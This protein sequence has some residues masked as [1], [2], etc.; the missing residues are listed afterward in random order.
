MYDLMRKRIHITALHLAALAFMNALSFAAIAQ[1]VTFTVNRTTDTTGSCTA[2]SCNLR[3]A[4]AAANATTTKDTIVFN[5][6]TCGTNV[7]NITGGTLHITRPVIIDGTT[8]PRCSTT[9]TGNSLI[10]LRGQGV[11]FAPVALISGLILDSTS[12]GSTIRG[13]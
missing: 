12:G 2:S 3:Q 10:E 5:L 9:P 11:N 1:S 8:Q 7:I 4:I 6:P 13:L